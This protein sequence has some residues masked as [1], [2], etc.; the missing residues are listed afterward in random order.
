[1]NICLFLYRGDPY[2]GGQG[3]Y[4]LNLT[5]AL[6]NQ[7]HQVTVLVGPPYPDPMP[8]ARVIKLPNKHYWGRK[9]REFFP[10]AGQ[11]KKLT[12][13][14]FLEFASSRTG[15]CP[16]A[17]AFSIRAA[18]EFKKLHRIEPFD[19]IHDVETLGYGLLLAR[20]SGVP[21]V[22][23]VH[24][25]LTRDL[26]TYVSKATRW[27]QRYHNVMFY[28]IMMQG[29]VARRVDGM[30]TS[31]IV[32]VNELIKA[33][34]V[35]KEKIH[36]VYSG[37]NIDNF[38]PAPS[39]KRNSKEILFV[40]NTGDPRKGFAF[41][42]E[43]L[44]D[45][46]DDI[47][48]TVVGRNDPDETYISKLSE[49]KNR[50]NFTGR[51]TEEELVALYRRTGVLVMP[52]LFEGFG[53][54]VAEGMACSAPVITT[55]AGSLPEVVGEDQEGGL[56]VPPGDSRS[57]AKALNKVLTEPDFA[58]DL[59]ERGRRRMERLFSWERTAENTARVY[60]KLIHDQGLGK[61]PAFEKENQY[62]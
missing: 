44:L 26:A 31:S 15:Y 35:K 38:S 25:P 51:I 6:A 58:K 32:G 33:F 46:P 2:C 57:L 27:R 45:L 34:K 62:A 60:Q 1:M 7:G 5:R 16:E 8:W 9:T 61:Q 11:D 12:H 59:G 50:V 52:S 48:I 42:L 41:L 14:D 29:L 54:P 55:M 24:H 40:G 43:A 37:V 36:L 56:L 18:R 19:V 4:I 49:L 3:I 23:T 20:A 28:P 47:H 30:I 39:V 22:S 53:L 13:L 10:G 17:L 21:A